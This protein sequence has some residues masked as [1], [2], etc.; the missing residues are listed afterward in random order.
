MRQIQATQN[1]L[2]YLEQNGRQ[3][4]REYLGYQ[5]IIEI[6]R[7]RLRIGTEEVNMVG[8]YRGYV[9]LAITEI[10]LQTYLNVEVP[11]V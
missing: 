8:F 9:L 10:I 3:G 1:Y 2:R 11:D 5:Y 7:M 4:S 6:Y